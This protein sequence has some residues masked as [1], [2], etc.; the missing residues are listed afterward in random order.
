MIKQAMEE[1]IKEHDKRSA[2]ALSGIDV[3]D[4]LMKTL[5]AMSSIEQVNTKELT[6]G[7]RLVLENGFSLEQAAEA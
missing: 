1:S 5:M 4:A 2:N 7:V 6:P 3:D